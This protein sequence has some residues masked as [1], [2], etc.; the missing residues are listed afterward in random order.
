VARPYISRVAALSSALQ[1]G[2]DRAP[3]GRA[4]AGRRFRSILLVLAGVPIA[5]A[6]LWYG[7]LT[8]LL[9][10]GQG[11]FVYTYLAG[12][13]ILARGGDPYQCNVG[14]CGGFPHYLLFY[15]PLVFWLAQPLVGFDSRLVSDI[16]LVVTN[17]FLFVFLWVVLRAL[18]VRD[19]QFAAVAILA[20]ISFAPTLT[21]IQNRNLQVAVLMLSAVL[22][23]AYMSGDRWWGGVA[24]GIGL[25]IKL[26]QAPLLLLSIWGRRVGLV[27]VTVVTWTVLWLVAAP[28]YLPEYL[29]R[30]APSQA[31]GSGEVINV[32]P[33]GT[34]NR[35]FHPESLYNSGLGG[36]ALVLILTAAFGVAVVIFTARRLGT[37][38]PDRD[39]RA[40]EVAVGVA[41]SPLLLTL[42]YAGQFVLL[43]LPMIVLLDFGLRSRSR[44]VVLAVA[45]SWL[46]VGPSYLWFTNA[47]ASGF[48][49]QLLF[50]VWSNSAVAGVIVL[51][52][53]TLHALELH[54]RQVAHP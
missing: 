38:R 7:L 21:E 36:G 52:I 6:Y 2:V 47:L 3:W 15:P 19:W 33:L 45:A 31:Q 13:R 49:F 50:E 40:L 42:V 53:A 10:A 25:A 29:L 32:A 35:L 41:A 44:P 17:I 26:I 1:P 4:L 20:S 39:G 46:L 18:R 8:P 22:L 5:L 27:A 16:A 28:Q 24:L 48:G 34:L 9:S 23:T 30:V 43:L 12:A 14:L 54:R 11:D 37:P 51:W